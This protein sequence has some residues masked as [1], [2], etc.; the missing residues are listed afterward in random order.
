ML[1]TC[2]VLLPLIPP[3]A[4]QAALASSLRWTLMVAGV[5]TFVAGSDM[6]SRVGGSLDK[7]LPWR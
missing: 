2:S 4:Q 7:A 6:A 5:L 3:V 1:I